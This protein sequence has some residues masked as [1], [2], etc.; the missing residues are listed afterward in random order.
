M[1]QYPR[2][3]ATNPGVERFGWFG[4]ARGLGCCQDRKVRFGLVGLSQ[5][6]DT[7]C[8][9]R[10]TQLVVGAA[11]SWLWLMTGFVVGLAGG[12][13]VAR[14]RGVVLEVTYIEI[15]RRA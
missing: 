6:G 13:A 4:H 8:R 7:L 5:I 14:L 3:D 12:G 1:S 11:G 15:Y 9:A 10:G 2:A